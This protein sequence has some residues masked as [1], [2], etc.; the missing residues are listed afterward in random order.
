MLFKLSDRETADTPRIVG[1][2]DEPAVAGRT[3]E[4]RRVTVNLTVTSRHGVAGTVNHRGDTDR[5]GDDY[6]HSGAT[7]MVTAT[8]DL[9]ANGTAMIPST[10]KFRRPH[11]RCNHRQFEACHFTGTRVTEKTSQSPVAISNVFIVD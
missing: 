2:S 6:R 3:S 11:W 8:A 9:T 1:A 5:H 4:Q 10:V 7:V